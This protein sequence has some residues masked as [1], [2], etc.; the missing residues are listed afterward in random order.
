MAFS[1]WRLGRAA[2]GQRDCCR[3]AQRESAAKTTNYSEC[4][5]YPLDNYVKWG[6][7]LEEATIS[8]LLSDICHTRILDFIAYA[9]VSCV[10]P[11]DRASY[12]YLNVLLG[13]ANVRDCLIRHG[14][15]KMLADQLSIIS[16]ASAT[17][18]NQ[19][20]DTCSSLLDPENRF[21]TYQETFSLPN[22]GDIGALDREDPNYVRE[23]D[24]FVRKISQAI[25]LHPDWP[26]N[27]SSSSASNGLSRFLNIAGA[28]AV[29]GNIPPSLSCAILDLIGRKSVAIEDQLQAVLVLLIPFMDK[30][31]REGSVLVDELHLQLNIF[32]M[33]SLA[34]QDPL[35][36][37]VLPRSRSNAEPPAHSRP[38]SQLH[39]IIRALKN[40][41]TLP[42]HSVQGKKAL[43][44]I[45][46][47]SLTIG[48]REPKESYFEF[49][50][51]LLLDIFDGSR[52]ASLDCVIEACTL[53]GV[54]THVATP[55]CILMDHPL[56]LGLSSGIS[57]L[58]ALFGRISGYCSSEKQLEEL[59]TPLIDL[60][61][62]VVDDLPL[63]IRL[64]RVFRKVAKSSVFAPLR[65]L[66][67]ALGRLNTVNDD[68]L[69]WMVF[70]L[71][72]DYQS[73]PSAIDRVTADNIVM[74]LLFQLV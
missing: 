20:F 2:E 49:L 51:L 21:S 19:L 53:A 71:L 4:Y 17:Y 54:W 13:L 40:L 48:V 30:S 63:E 72:E 23:I 26:V 33:V 41:V 65:V 60:F 73:C 7:Y 32:A 10:Y 24:D 28:I 9:N 70:A 47:E 29:S 14:I 15:L 43:P 52:G 61:E 12:R 64:L 74:D 56:K 45:I 39:R 58:E 36:E 16:Q 44:T 55:A 67:L 1:F 46:M 6:Q 27:I 34:C 31:S 69:F 35:L 68:G 42:C 59:L 22:H 57:A 50:L 8:T 62:S 3:L 66:H 11:E 5:K 18:Q 37:V 38:S 25:L